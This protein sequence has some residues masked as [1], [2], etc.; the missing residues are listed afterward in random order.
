[1]NDDDLKA[2]IGMTVADARGHVEARGLMLRVV[3]EDGVPLM[4]TA[5]HRRDRVNVAVVAGKVESADIG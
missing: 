2:L 5:D 4:T 3:E 1:M